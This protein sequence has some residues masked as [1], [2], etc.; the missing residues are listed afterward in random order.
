MSKTVILS[1]H[2]QT[3]FVLDIPAS[4]EA[5]QGGGRICSS[6]PLETSFVAPEPKGYK[7]SKF[8]AT[9]PTEHVAY[10]IEISSHCERALAAVKDSPGLRPWCLPRVHN[11]ELNDVSAKRAVTEDHRTSSLPVVLS[12]TQNDFPSMRYVQNQLIHNDNARK[13]YLEFKDNESML[14]P[15]NCTFMW[16]SSRR[17][18]WTMSELS[19][20]AM[21][22]KLCCRQIVNV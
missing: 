17:G 18:R 8:I 3:V 19:T 5:A 13:A 1:S 16:S 6:V 15:S 4:I 7:R 11:A 12:T 20:S 9:L 22:S 10:H 14:I 2:D 21:H